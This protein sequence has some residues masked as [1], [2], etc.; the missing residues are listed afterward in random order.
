MFVVVSLL[1]GLLA[2]GQAQT[3]NA[4]APSAHDPHVRPLEKDADR[5]MAKGLAKSPTFRRLVSRLEHSDVVVYVRLGW[6]LPV[7]IGGRLHFLA[8]H[9][10]SRYLVVDLNR[11][12]ARSALVA[13]LGHELQHAVEVAEAPDVTS[14]ADLRVL[15]RRVGIQTGPDRYDSIAARRAGYDVLREEAANRRHS[16]R[17][18]SVMG[19]LTEIAE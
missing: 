1:M 18:A 19:S 16:T 10:E 13:L 12:L 8:V 6:D 17:E 5:L 14:S 2:A 4:A 7:R 11:A 3:L 9:G 15:Y